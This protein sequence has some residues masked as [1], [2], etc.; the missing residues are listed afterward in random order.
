MFVL[1]TLILEVNIVDILEYFYVNIRINCIL[2]LRKDAMRVKIKTIVSMLVHLD[3]S[4]ILSSSFYN[5][6]FLT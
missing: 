6:L 1:L 4:P 5:F 3:R 2:A